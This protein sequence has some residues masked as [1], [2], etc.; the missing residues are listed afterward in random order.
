MSFSISV[1][2]KHHQNKSSSKY[3]KMEK[4]LWHLIYAFRASSF[5]QEQ[6]SSL[7]SILLKFDLWKLIMGNISFFMLF[8]LKFNVL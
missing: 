3:L 5:L 4:L 2:N 6:N 7:Y 1:P 8:F